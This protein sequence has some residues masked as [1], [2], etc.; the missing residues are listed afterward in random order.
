M[1]KWLYILLL[2]VPLLTGCH[3]KIWEMLND[4]ERRIS[5]LEEF[6]NKLNTNINSLQAMVDAINTSDLIKDVQPV[7]QDGQIVG[8]TITFYNSNPI[9][10]YN[11][12]DGANGTTP[13]IGI[14]SED[15]V[16]YWTIDGEW[17]LDDDGNKVRADAVTPKMKI[18]DEYWWVSYDNG[19]SWTQLDKAI[20]S[21]DSIFQNVYQDN[22]YYYFVLANGEVIQ[23]VKGGL[24]FEYV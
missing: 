7:S 14:K 17:I 19:A 5:A 13:L 22:R 8:Y 12:K 23:I 20:T 10:I 6:C 18:E 21:G 11:G 15:G 1:K 3:K 24:T 4:H 16:Y 2:M 9:T